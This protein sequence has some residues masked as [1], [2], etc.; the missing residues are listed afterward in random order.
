MNDNY[1]LDL[2]QRLV[3]LRDEVQKI[4]ST[5]NT[6]EVV[7]L[8][9]QCQ[10]L[11]DKLN[12]DEVNEIVNKAIESKEDV[13]EL[14]NV[15]ANY[16][17]DKDSDFIDKELSQLLDDCNKDEAKK[18]K[19]EF[20]LNKENNNKMNVKKENLKVAEDFSLVIEDND[21]V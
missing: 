1:I 10:K 18:I 6:S 8:L 7:D 15:F 13:N 9:K 2:N 14:N 16:Q 12:L 19:N 20:S 3:Y 17:N 4:N 21:F 11:D 5:K